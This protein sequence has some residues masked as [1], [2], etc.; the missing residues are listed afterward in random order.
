MKFA[1]ILCNHLVLYKLNQTFFATNDRS[2]TWR[3]DCRMEIL[4]LCLHTPGR[5]ILMLRKIRFA[6]IFLALSLCSLLALMPC[7]QAQQTLGGITGT[8]TDKTGGV[9]PGTTVIIV[10]DQT[11][12]TRSQKSNDNGSYD[13]VNLPIGTYTLTFTHDG[14]ETQKI[15]AITVQADRTATVNAVLP[16][17]KVGTVVEVDANPLMNA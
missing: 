3:H 13:F 5:F 16:V 17:G 2:T 8:V 1:Y 14:F 10:G 12:L 11:Q 15:P 4:H 7:A 6:G 9:L